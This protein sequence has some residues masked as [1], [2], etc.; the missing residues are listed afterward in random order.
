VRLT[1]QSQG[2][3]LGPTKQAHTADGAGERQ[4]T[5]SGQ[6]AHHI[7]GDTK[8]PPDI[9]CHH[10]VIRGPNRSRDHPR[11]RNAESALALLDPDWP[12][13]RASRSFLG[14]IWLAGFPVL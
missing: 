13:A 8:N 12:A 9:G 7:N 11:S 5:V 4:S 10:E 6:K 14:N 3:D 1:P 2:I